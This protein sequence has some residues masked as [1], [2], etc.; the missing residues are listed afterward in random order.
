MITQLG[1]SNRLHD[2]LQLL[3]LVH[4][5]LL[6]RGFLLLACLVLFVCVLMEEPTPAF[7]SIITTIAKFTFSS[8]SLALS[9]PFRVVIALVTGI[10][11]D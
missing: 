3:P 5:N 8:F 1:S 11:V 6:L 2:L 7:L 10:I 9:L 4:L